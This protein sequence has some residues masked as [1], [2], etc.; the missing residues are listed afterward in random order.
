M[1]EKLRSSYRLAVVPV[2][3][4]WGACSGYRGEDVAPREAP[5]LTIT[6]LDPV[7]GPAGRAYP[8]RL[9]IYG[10]GFAETGNVVDF[11]PVSIRDLPST[12]DGT[13]LALSVPKVVPSRGEAPPFVLTPGEYRVTVTTPS[14]RSDPLTFRLIN[15]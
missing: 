12:D 11:G 7:S 14:G 5:V 4:L 2:V 13:R 1:L 10:T 3:F 8:I 15:P 6:R 9:T